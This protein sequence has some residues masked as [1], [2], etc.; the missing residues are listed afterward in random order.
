MTL[1]QATQ[2]H[3]VHYVPIATTALSVVFCAV[4]ARRYL[5]FGG[6]HLLWWGFGIACYGLG[7]ALEATITLAGNT[8]ALNK[9]WY[10]AGALFGGYPLAQG[11]VYLL[12]RRRTAHILT[13][14][15]VPLILVLSV[16][17]ILSPTN[18]DALLS[19]K[20]GGS[21][22]GWQWIRPWTPIV[23]L[24]AAAFLIGGA[25]L[26]AA[27]YARHSDTKHR[28]IG[29]LL[30]AIGAILP[31][32]GGGMAKAGYV[33]ALYVGEF[34]G[35]ILIWLGYASCVRRP[36]ELSAPSAAAVPAG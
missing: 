15:T 18:M 14:L 1:A 24:Y 23:N 26:S 21:A 34:F 31:G 28:M 36:A 4:L 3:L 7:T 27:R 29:N 33:E 20:P 8:P 30:I 9:A 17:V 19:H 2:P 6:A 22:L 5:L 12:L 35:I 10:I 11:T 16:L 32:V 13:A 25:V